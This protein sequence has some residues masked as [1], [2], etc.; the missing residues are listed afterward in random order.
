MSSHSKYQQGCSGEIDKMALKLIWK[1]QV[2]KNNQGQLEENKNMDLYFHIINIH[3]A[4]EI[5]KTG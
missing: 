4:A 5:M 2:P 3:S 1:C